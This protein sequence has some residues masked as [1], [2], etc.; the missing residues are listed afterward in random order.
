ML[1]SLWDIRGDADKC[2]PSLLISMLRMSL[3]F[4]LGGMLYWKSK[5]KGFMSQSTNS[6]KKYLLY[7]FGNFH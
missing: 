2:S 7:L 5:F 4:S 3:C 1:L 6:N